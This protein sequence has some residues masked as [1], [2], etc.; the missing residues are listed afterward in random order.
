MTVTLALGSCVDRKVFGARPEHLCFYAS[1]ENVLEAVYA[2]GRPG[3]IDARG[4]RF[5]PG[6]SGS[7]VLVTPEGWI[8]YAAPGNIEKSQ[9]TLLLWFKPYWDIKAQELHTIVR[10]DGDP[11]SGDNAC[12][13]MT[14]PGWIQFLLG[15]KANHFRK[16]RVF[17]EP[18]EWHHVAVTWD[19]ARGTRFYVD[20]LPQS[21]NISD[22]IHIEEPFSWVA[23][24]HKEIILGEAMAPETV[25]PDNQGIAYDEVK[26]FSRILTDQEVLEEY[27]GSVVCPYGYIP[28]NVICPNKR[29]TLKLRLVNRCSGS[30]LIG[31]LFCEIVRTDHVSEGQYEAGP[32]EL[33]AASSKEVSLE[34]PPLAPGEYLLITKW[35]RDDRCLQHI[36]LFVYE[37]YKEKTSRS[38]HAEG[39]TLTTILCARD[40]RS[41]LFCSD[42]GTR[43][44]EAAFGPYLEG[45][46]K[47]FSRFAFRFRVKNPHVPHRVVVAYPDDKERIFDMVI[48]GPDSPQNYDVGTGVFIGNEYPLTNTLQ[49]HTIM[50]WPRQRDNAIT[51]MSWERGKPAAAAEIKVEEL[52]DGLEPLGLDLPPPGTPQRLVGLYWEDSRLPECLGWDGK[53]PIG[54]DQGIRNLMEYM[55]HMGMNALMYPTVTYGGPYYNS[56]REGFRGSNR[57]GS[58]PLNFVEILLSRCAEAGVSFYAI[59]N[60]GATV[61]LVDKVVDAQASTPPEAMSFRTITKDNKATKRWGEALRSLFNPLH[62]VVQEEIK[63][64]VREHIDRFGRAD[65]FRGIAFHLVSEN[66]TWLGSLDQIYDDYTIAEFEKDTGVVIPI[67]QNDAKRFSKRYQWLMRNA[68]SQWVQWRCRRVADFYAEV[69]RMMQTS[70]QD[71]ELVLSVFMP[72]GRGVDHARWSIGHQSVEDMLL[73]AG[74]DIGMLREIPGIRIQRFFHPADYR[75]MKLDRVNRDRPVLEA[76]HARDMFFDPKA[77]SVFLDGN[78]IATNVFHV[79]FEHD[80]S[81]DPLPGFW[82]EPLR[83][84]VST[85][86]AG[87]M[88]FMEYP[89]HAVA[90]FDPWLFTF[91]CFQIPTIGHEER[92]RPFIKALRALPAVQ[93]QQVKGM[94]DPVVMRLAACGADLYLYVVNRESYPV[95]V[96]WLVQ[97]KNKAP[98]SMTDLVAGARMRL[99]G[100]GQ[101][102]SVDFQLGPYELRP[103]RVRPLSVEILRPRCVVPPEVD[104][105]LRQR[106]ESLKAKARHSW[107]RGGQGK[108]LTETLALLEEAFEEDPLPYS[109]IKHLLESYAAR[110]LTSE[111]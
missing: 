105:D 63:G 20:G 38:L 41:E 88:Y 3:P 54:F 98:V 57:Y 74:F 42:K 67:A 27:C 80:A 77:L 16:G 79:Y 53:T 60:V 62:P 45:G 17:W 69:A 86:A 65:A 46:E 7:A 35:N 70:R 107:P 9:G 76:V 1:F 28:W 97:A 52:A 110:K 93:F 64:L 30:K 19:H 51:F 21:Y 15:D 75:L 111:P 109:R 90:T 44:V 8:R 61:N 29:A 48:N 47:E 2:Q 40:L 55:Q 6:V 71:R 13:L 56:E 12:T 10:E 50:F 78:N 99:G 43:I 100:Q 33:A 95:E 68:K 22:G 108:E 96:R 94:E 66:L 4:Y 11:A 37:P 59:F 14:Y 103:F 18:L 5:V 81:R 102:R 23:E 39:Q 73:E 87:H 106:F 26:L 32:V 82:W 89:A 92:L 31:R 25:G 91:C 104:K 24:G 36:P 34:H 49:F 83:G 101:L 85:I 84:N 72:C 58:H